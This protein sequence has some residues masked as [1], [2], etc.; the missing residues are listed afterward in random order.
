MVDNVVLIPFFDEL[1]LLD[2]LNALDSLVATLMKIF[3]KL[4]IF[5]TTFSY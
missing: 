3:M 4:Y 2:S 1:I 5:S